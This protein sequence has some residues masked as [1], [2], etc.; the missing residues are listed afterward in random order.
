MCHPSSSSGVNTIPRA[1]QLALGTA[2]DTT[3]TS[4]VMPVRRHDEEAVHV[5]LPNH[6]SVWVG[7]LLF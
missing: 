7:V 5:P 3:R 4:I 1:L 2:R 6:V